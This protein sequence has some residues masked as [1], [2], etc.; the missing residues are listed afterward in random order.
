MTGG[1]SD[2]IR[3]DVAHFPPTAA[4]V[5]DVRASTVHTLTRWSVDPDDVDVAE[6][7]VCELASN[8]VKASGPDDV[9][10]L[11]L[12]ICDAVLT[13]EI[14]DASTAPPILIAAR[15]DQESG[16]GLVLVDAVSLRWAWYP[17]RTGGKVTWAQL[18]AA[19]TPAV[20]T[21]NSAALPTRAA[22][23]VPAPAAPVAFHDDPATLRRVID[24][25]RALDDWH[26]PPPGRG[27]RDRAPGGQTPKVPD[28]FVSPLDAETIGFFSPGISRTWPAELSA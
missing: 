23:P 14:W 4:A 21:D 27:V 18:P 25:L 26:R 6:V 11:R 10:A 12:T 17:G 28:Q 1:I 2:A 5:P 8:A 20:P 13:I 9:V 16:R 3:V 15:P 22:T 19:T 7:V 24:R